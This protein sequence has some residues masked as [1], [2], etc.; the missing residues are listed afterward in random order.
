MHSQVAAKMLASSR[1]LK[2]GKQREIKQR[3]QTWGSM[4]P[5]AAEEVERGVLLRYLF[6]GADTETCFS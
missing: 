6:P 1:T 5:A 4:Q 3:R 2:P